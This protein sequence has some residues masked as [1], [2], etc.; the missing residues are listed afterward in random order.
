MKYYL[1]D[2]TGDWADEMTIYGLMLLTE[3]EY[4]TWRAKLEDEEAGHFPFTYG[5]GTNE[6]IEYD[7]FEDMFS[8][9]TVKEVTKEQ[10]DVLKATI[11]Q[12]QED[13]GMFPFSHEWHFEQNQ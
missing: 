4:Q 11:F 6:E 3:E 1:L 9:I 8:N 5:V 10:Y 12:N 2:Y 7:S 13:Y